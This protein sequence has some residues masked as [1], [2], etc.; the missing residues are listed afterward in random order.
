MSAPLREVTVTLDDGAV[1][2]LWISDKTGGKGTDRGFYATV[3][4]GSGVFLLTA[5]SARRFEVS[6]DELEKLP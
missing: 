4:D 2:V 6:L 5:D 3:R 1:H